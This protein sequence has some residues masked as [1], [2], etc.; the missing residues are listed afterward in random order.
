MEELKEREGGRREGEMEKERIVNCDTDPTFFPLPSSRMQLRSEIDSLN[1]QLDKTNLSK[2]IAESK[3]SDF[4]RYKT[5][6]ELEI[7]E[8][9]ARHKMV[10][11]EKVA[12]SAQVRREGGG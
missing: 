7:T 10:M 9:L 11:T 4:D 12:R 3:L 6:I 2:S 1:T 5:M 8:M